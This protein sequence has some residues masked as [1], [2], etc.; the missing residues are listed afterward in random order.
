ML[1]RFQPLQ[2]VHVEVA[3]DVWYSSDCSHLTG[4]TPLRGHLMT[5]AGSRGV[6]SCADRQS[7]GRLCEER[8]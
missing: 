4:N 3:S 5:A 7:P 2:P 6:F 1:L 8:P